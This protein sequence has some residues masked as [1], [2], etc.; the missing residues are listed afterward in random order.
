MLGILVLCSKLLGLTPIHRGLFP[1][2]EWSE[3]FLNAKSW[4]SAATEVMLTWN[5]LGAATMQVTSHNRATKRLWRDV[6][7][8]ALL[9]LVV[10][11]LSAFLANTCHQILFARGGYG[12]IPSSFGKLA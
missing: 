4:I 1:Q 10:L 3:F 6:I 11:I 9:T 2:T 7:T 12:Y 8:I 5:L